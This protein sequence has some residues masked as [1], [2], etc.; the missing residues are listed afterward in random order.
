MFVK[1]KTKIHFWHNDQS[2]KY[3]T[4]SI[5][6]FALTLFFSYFF[7]VLELTKY[8][9]PIKLKQCLCHIL[10]HLQIH[11]SQIQIYSL[12]FLM[13]LR[14]KAPKCQGTEIL[15]STLPSTSMFSSC[16]NSAIQYYFFLAKNQQHFNQFF[17]PSCF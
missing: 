8:F 11:Q 2:G 12:F 16:M 6:I 17:L 9:F 14:M 4:I 10:H 5:L 3:T 13:L 15:S 7:P 1:S